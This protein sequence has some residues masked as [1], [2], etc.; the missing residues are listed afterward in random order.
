MEFLNTQVN[1]MMTATGPTC[2]VSLEAVSGPNPKN[3]VLEVKA[4]RPISFSQE[5]TTSMA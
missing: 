1:W 4:E 5:Q 3:S 2:I